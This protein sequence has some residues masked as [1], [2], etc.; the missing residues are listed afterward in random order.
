MHKTA[1]SKETDAIRLLANGFFSRLFLHF[2]IIWKKIIIFRQGLLV[3]YH[4]STFQM[5]NQIRFSLFFCSPPKST[6]HFAFNVVE[7]NELNG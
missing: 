4:K 3:C 1:P 5:H 2:S 7:L 6:I